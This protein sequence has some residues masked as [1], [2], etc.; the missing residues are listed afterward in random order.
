MVL[1]NISQAKAELSKLIEHVIQG[2]EVVIGKAGKP[3]AK[4]IPFHGSVGTR[5]PGSLKGKI[6]V[7]S[8]FDEFSPEIAELFG[9][10]SKRR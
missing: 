8:D 9:V 7:A 3:V 4:I 5:T 6:K 1:K 10:P 2:G